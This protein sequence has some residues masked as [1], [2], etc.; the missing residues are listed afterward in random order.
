M[1][2]LPLRL[3]ENGFTEKEERVNTAIHALGIVFGLFAVPMLVMSAAKKGDFSFLSV[4]I[5]G[6]CFLMTFTFSTIYHGLRKEPTKELFKKFDRI[7]IYFFIAGT[8]TP[9][10][11]HYLYDQTGM[12]LLTTVW[13][14]VL[15]GV[16]FEIYFV[17]KYFLLSVFFYLVMGWMFLFVMNRFFAAMPGSVVRL[18]L[19]GVALYSI[20]VVFFVWKKWRY[21]HAIWHLMVLIASICHYMAVMFTVSPPIE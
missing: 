10:V 12:M 13:A 21:H 17:N 9:L 20:G 7:S 14:L 15:L 1:E 11:L 16:L 18:V 3:N 8:Y 6:L 19:S 5:Y 4:V 2:T